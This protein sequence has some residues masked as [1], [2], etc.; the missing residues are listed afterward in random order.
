M[1]QVLLQPS[2]DTV[3]PSSHSSAGS[4]IELPQG[5]EPLRITKM[6]MKTQIFKNIFYFNKNI[7]KR[8]K[9]KNINLIKSL[10]KIFERKNI[11][12][13]C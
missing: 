1:L 9:M 6:L 5:E 12:F 4:T 8:K 2:P 11:F 3:F 7:K 10:K 13:F